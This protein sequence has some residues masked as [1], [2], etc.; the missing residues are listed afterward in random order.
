MHITKERLKNL[1]IQNYKKVGRAIPKPQSEKPRNNVNWT[2]DHNS[3]KEN[4]ILDRILPITPKK[5]FKSDTFIPE[6]R[7]EFVFTLKVSATE[8]KMP[9]EGIHRLRRDLLQRWNV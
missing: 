7:R 1:E 2:D 6:I 8:L 3:T 9:E 5:V 4:K